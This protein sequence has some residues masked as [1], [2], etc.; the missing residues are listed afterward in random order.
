MIQDL[1]VTVAV[2][3]YGVEAY[4]ERCATSLFEQTYENIEYIFVNDCTKDNSLRLLEKVM[5]K[6]PNRKPQVKIINHRV[7][8]GLGAARNTALEYASGEFIMWVDSDD[9][10]HKETVEKCCCNQHLT[11]AD[12]I[13]FGCYILSQ[14]QTKRL[15][16]AVYD[17]PI[18]FSLALFM[19]KTHGAVWGRLIRKQLY[20]D[21]NIRV[22][23]GINMGE[24]FQV[25]PRLSYF[26]NSIS[27]IDEP[28]YYYDCSS[29]SSYT[30]LYSK[31]KFTQDWESFDIIKN[32]F[33]QFNHKYDK[34]IYLAELKVIITDFVFSARY[35]DIDYY[36]HE[37]RKRLGQI[38]RKYWSF[39]SI[40]ERLLLVLSRNRQIMSIYAN[41]ATNIKHFIENFYYR[42]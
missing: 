26:A 4:I 3:I 40:P 29:A 8:R 1:K 38:N 35:K 30:N 11:N 13:S 20:L 19:R 32:F 25:M 6:Y 23:E 2:P 15:H 27:F 36:Y 28:L 10:I 41:V 14:N 5:E 18:E 24:D 34:E 22:K 42:R 21:H 12:I 37:S 9:Y 16:I 31:E 7:N 33:A 17:N 39:Y